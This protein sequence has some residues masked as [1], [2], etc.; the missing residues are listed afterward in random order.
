[1]K[2]KYVEILLYD[3][4]FFINNCVDDGNYFNGRLSL[5]RKTEFI[6]F[7]P[8]FGAHEVNSNLKYQKKVSII[9]E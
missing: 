8:E 9:A 2:S 3:K 1:M 7:I 4:F 6:H 5:S